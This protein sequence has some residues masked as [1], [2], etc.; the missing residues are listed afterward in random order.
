M[1]SYK[2]DSLY[3]L[4]TDPQY[5]TRKTFLSIVIEKIGVRK[6][7]FSLLLLLLVALVL[8]RAYLI[9]YMSLID[10][11]IAGIIGSIIT[12]FIVDFLLTYDKRIKLNKINARNNDFFLLT[13]RGLMANIL[14]L[15]EVI[16]YKELSELSY[17]IPDEKFGKLVRDKKIIISRIKKL[18]EYSQRNLRFFINLKL[19]WDQQNKL[20]T[21][22]YKYR[23]YIDPIIEYK[24]KYG[25]SRFISYIGGTSLTM[26]QSFPNSAPE[27]I[28]KPRFVKK[29]WGKTPQ[30]AYEYASKLVNDDPHN[31]AKE[32][33]SYCEVLEELARRSEKESLAV[34]I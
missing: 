2:G 19:L 1:D 33:I 6:I 5:E 10:N 8:V 23:P 31:F 14:F 22:L 7:I 18:T 15:F 32:I 16:D 25:T 34:F 27:Y 3:K 17:G 12:I 28:Y 21:F 11:I 24:V 20:E 29:K 4:A 26:I 13:V 30:K 9:V